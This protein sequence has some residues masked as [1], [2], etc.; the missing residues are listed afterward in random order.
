[1]TP[2]NAA[3]N[4][5]TCGCSADQ[6]PITDPDAIRE[7]VRARYAS[8]SRDVTASG[9]TAGEPASCCG[10]D[11]PVITPEQRAVFGS[12]LYGDD[13]RDLPDNAVLASLGCGTP[14]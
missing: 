8:S 12:K 1:M 13:Q 10:S 14:T 2:E 3:N 11:T 6:V 5:S 9:T 4:K 7:S